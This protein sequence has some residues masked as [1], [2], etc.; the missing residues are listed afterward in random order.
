MKTIL[1]KTIAVILF[2]N[3]VFT[4]RG[5]T[6]NNVDPSNR[7]L[8]NGVIAHRGA[9]KKDNLPQNSIAS[10]KNAIRI[11][12]AGSEF[13]VQLTADEVLIV[14]H[15]QD[16]EGMKIEE[17]DYTILAKYL[18]KNG[19]T[20][21]TLENYIKTGIGQC[22]TR[23]I[24]ELKPSVISK[25]RSLL[26]AQ[27]VVEKIKQMNAQN[28]I[29]YIS[30]DYAILKEIL[31]QDNSAKTMY[32]GGDILPSQLKADKIY[33]ADYHYDVYKTDDHW[34]SKSHD[35]GVQTNVWTVNDSLLMDYFL[36][37][38]IDYITT[39]EP[40]MLLR[41]VNDN[42]Y[43][44]AW[45]LVWAE[46]FNYFGLPDSTKWSYD[47]SKN[48]KGWGNNE[49]QWYNAANLQNT[50]VSDGTLKII[51]IEQATSNNKYSSGRLST[52]SKG[53]WKYGK[54]EVRAKLP[55]GNGTWPAIWMLSSDNS[56]GGWPKSGE[57]DIMEHVGYDTD[58]VHSTVHTEKYNHVKGT[59]VGK[60]TAVKTATT[61]FHVYS[62][63]WQENE[64]R[65]YVDGILY[66][67][68]PKENSGFEAW[69]FDQRFHLILN[70]AIGGNWGGIQGIDNS[71]FPHVLEIDY[72]RVYEAICTKSQ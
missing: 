42:I 5:Q 16:Y 14:N 29:I 19:E 49:A 26:L 63:E 11:G 57:I 67:S 33:G 69:P 61:E 65:S 39:D 20:L 46:E 36:A 59:Q 35:V 13:D 53:D 41:K 37:R 24:L 23:L 58:T 66:F 27:K 72:V 4:L 2:L 43:N 30:F 45:T 48:S 55:S 10:L 21:P 28:W 8:T 54:V 52:K 32:L 71:R 50:Q 1:F 51:A 56:Y 60:A 15:D 18:L 62:I 68:F 40:E 47:T 25:E 64:I 44:S 38:N 22:Q 12:V 17:T 31:H 3:I 9:W 6:Y 7:F 70:L 34:I